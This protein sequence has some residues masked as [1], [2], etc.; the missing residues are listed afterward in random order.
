MTGVVLLGKI[1]QRSGVG[2][3]NRAKCAALP[4]AALIM[5]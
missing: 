2:W 4:S 1:W 3:M 5:R